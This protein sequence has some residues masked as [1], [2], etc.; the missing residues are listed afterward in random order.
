MRGLQRR[1]VNVGAGG[2][3]G[4]EERPM[5]AN[6]ARKLSERIARGEERPHSDIRELAPRPAAPLKPDPAARS[7]LHV[8]EGT[9]EASAASLLVS[10][11][12]DAG[13]D[14]FFGIPGG[15]VSPI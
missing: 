13:V 2:T 14:T 8:S 7:P 10:A 5:T 9:R 11:L 1:R 12:V 6:E 4:T 3:T 15:P